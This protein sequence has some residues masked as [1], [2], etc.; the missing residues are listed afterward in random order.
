MAV[1]ILDVMSS[2]L[3]VIGLLAVVLC[4]CVVTYLA[5][6]RSVQRELDEVR[7]QVAEIAGMRSVVEELAKANANAVT[8]AA[9]PAPVVEMPKAVATP[10]APKPMP[11]A[12]PPP[13]PDELA[14]ETLVVIAAA[15]AAFLGKS[16][17]LRSARLIQ[18]V[19]ESPWAQQGR[20]YIQASHNLARV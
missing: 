6:R 9:K 4:A 12:P 20:V 16:V 3:G 19:G 13:K 5:M 2:G 1:A 11:A 8:A 15:V 10:E 7:G 14:H 17:R 18:P